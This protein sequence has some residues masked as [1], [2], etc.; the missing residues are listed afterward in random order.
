MRRCFFTPVHFLLVVAL[1][2]VTGPS[3]YAQTQTAAEFH[4]LRI[5][6]RGV[7]WVQVVVDQV[8]VF[9]GFLQPGEWRAWQG[10][11]LP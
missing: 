1:Y 7:S 2:L 9:N 11:R 4:S 3:S 8:I 10:N 5:G 6:C